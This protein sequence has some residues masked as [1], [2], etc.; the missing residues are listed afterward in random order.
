M[1]FVDGRAVTCRAER[2]VSQMP[3]HGAMTRRSIQLA[4]CTMRCFTFA[5]RGLT[6]KRV[7]PQPPLLN[8]QFLLA[9]PTRTR[10]EY[11][12]HLTLWHHLST[13]PCNE[14]VSTPRA[15]RLSC[16]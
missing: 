11:W 12:R 4:L 8:G 3:F 5:E 13:A 10:L 6:A 9:A 16:I 1:R 14:S 15:G 2:V 7:L